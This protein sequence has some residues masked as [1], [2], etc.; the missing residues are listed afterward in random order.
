[1]ISQAG[2]KGGT[3]Q[4]IPVAGR[5]SKTIKAGAKAVNRL[6]V[7]KPLMCEFALHM[8]M[9]IAHERSRSK[10]LEPLIDVP[11]ATA[12]GGRKL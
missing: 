9:Q 1:M 11:L 3:L 8:P 6:C 4:E 7:G 10:P 12:P 5:V 2:S